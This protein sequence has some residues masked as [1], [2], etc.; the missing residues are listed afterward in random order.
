MGFQVGLV[1]VLV[2]AEGRRLRE[3]LQ[4]AL[5]ADV[6]VGL[7]Q[8]AALHLIYNIL[9]LRF[10]ARLHQ[11]VAGLNLCCRIAQACPVGHHDAVEAP[12]VAQDGGQQFAVLL[13]ERTVQ[14]VIRRHHRPGSSLAH[15]NLESFQVDFAE[16]TLRH[17]LVD[18]HAVGLL[19]VAGEVLDGGT[20]PLTLNASHVGGGNLARHYRVF[21]I[22]FEVTPAERRAV[23]V[24]AWGEQHVAAVLQHLVADA[25][26]HLLNE[27][28]VPCAGKG[29]AH[30]EARAEVGVLVVVA[31]RTD[32]HAGRTV[33]QHR[34]GDA[35]PGN[36]LSGTGSTGHALSMSANHAIVVGRRYLAVATHHEH[37][38]LLERHGFEDFV[39]I[40]ALQLH[41]RRH[42][43]HAP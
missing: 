28:C 42:R 6:E 25:A 24:H 41:L 30:G 43:A 16:G 20:H 17:H 22:V 9:Y 4:D 37:G 33:G 29:C 12:L 32:S 15:G 34:R 11:V 5:H 21:G 1:R 3:I 38:F 18:T 2:V 39:N 31:A 10:V 13:G 26:S 35:E 27:L 36:G 23:D 14:S 19:R 8:R 40:V 7:F